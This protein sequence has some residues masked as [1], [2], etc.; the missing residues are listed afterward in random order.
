MSVLA[1]A[2]EHHVPGAHALTEYSSVS[3]IAEPSGFS[4][5]VR[6]R[7]RVESTMPV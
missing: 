1:V 2:G 7:A 6:L 3:R 4:V 5:T